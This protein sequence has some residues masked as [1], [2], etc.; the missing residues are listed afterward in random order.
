MSTII[1]GKTSALSTQFIIYDGVRS[2][3]RQ[4][5]IASACTA[6]W[7]AEMVLPELPARLR[8]EG[9]LSVRPTT[10]LR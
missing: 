9:M 7:R 1:G 3:I 6:L 5:F 8:R 2:I 4:S 10:P